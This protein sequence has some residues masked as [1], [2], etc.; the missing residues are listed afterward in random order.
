MPFASQGFAV[1]NDVLPG[2]ELS[3]A[4]ELV[5]RLIARHR[6]GEEAVISMGVSV[7]TV[8]NQH[9]QRNPGVVAGQWQLEPYIIGNLVSLDVRFAALFSAQSIWLCAADLL[10]CLQ[11][12]VV[13]HFS[14]IT[15]KPPLAGP[16][17]GW[18]R[19]AHNTYFASSDRRTVRLLLPLQPMN[20][21]NGGTEVVAGSHLSRAEPEGPVCCP[22]VSPGSCLA[23]HSEVLHGGAPNRS[24]SERDVIV[25]QFGVVTSELQHRAA[26]LLSLSAREDIVRFSRENCGL[27][28]LSLTD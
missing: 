8:T 6:S 18:H 13:F 4:R 17:V 15:R 9:P 26:E 28:S 27:S 23:L 19:D 11:E 3:L 12:Q 24:A 2:P 1:M 10:S 21:T 14:N 16:A 20:E 5:S 25:L 7:A 22:Q